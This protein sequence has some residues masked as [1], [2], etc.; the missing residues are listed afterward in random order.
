MNQKQPQQLLQ[1]EACRAGKVELSLFRCDIFQTTGEF[2]AVSWWQHRAALHNAALCFTALTH[3][4]GTGRGCHAADKE[5]SGR[6]ADHIKVSHRSLNG[7]VIAPWWMQQFNCKHGSCITAGW[8]F[9]LSEL[10]LLLPL[11]QGGYCAEKGQNPPVVW[12]FLLLTPNQCLSLGHVSVH[13]SHAVV[14]QVLWD[15]CQ[16]LFGIWLPA[17]PD[18]RRDPGECWRVGI[19]HHK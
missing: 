18:G 17:E 3:P 6:H 10:W 7:R 16:M 4:Q 9:A 5:R 15:P 2:H 11:H 12:Q 8:R 13:T 14:R 1:T 19:I